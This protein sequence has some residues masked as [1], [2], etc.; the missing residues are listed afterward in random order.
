VVDLGGRDEERAR[1]GQ[2]ERGDGKGSDIELQLRQHL[3]DPPRKKLV[4]E[5]SRNH[6]H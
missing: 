3:G 6:V 4:V 1:I 5:H 2:K